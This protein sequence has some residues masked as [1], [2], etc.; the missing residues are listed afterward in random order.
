VIEVYYLC[1]LLGYKG[2]YRIYLE[3]Q[4]KGVIQNVADH[5][6]RLNRLQSGELS[7]HWR[8]TDQ[9][10]LPKDPGTPLWVKLGGGAALVLLVFVYLIFYLLLESNVRDALGRSAY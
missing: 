3:D 5:L 1:L 4:L 10:E 2:K 8:A 7:P 6:R 9:P